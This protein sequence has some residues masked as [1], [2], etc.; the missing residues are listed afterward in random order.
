MLLV[1]AW[2]VAPSIPKLTTLGPIYKKVEIT[3]KFVSE[4]QPSEQHY[5]YFF[6]IV[7]LS[8]MRQMKLTLVEGEY[9]DP[10]AALSLP[11]HKLELWP[12][13]VIRV[14]RHKK[15]ILLCCEISQKI[16]RTESVL[17]QIQQVFKR[18]GGDSSYYSSVEKLLLGTNVITRCNNLTYRQ[19]G[20]S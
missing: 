11:Q 9:F 2:E 3:V 12:G 17:V 20:F 7:H 15:D 16:L 13:Y 10:Q 8:V 19:G 1:T 6:N 14:G 5:M 4:V 18:T